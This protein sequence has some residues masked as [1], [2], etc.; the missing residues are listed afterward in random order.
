MESGAGS[1]RESQS[2]RKRA[3]ILDAATSAFL[4]NG[5]VG[6]SIDQ[7][8]A[9][10]GVSKPTVYKHFADKER[11]FNEI[12]LGTID[13]VG[14]PV[15]DVT[16]SLGD[17]D[18][19]NAALDGLA[20]NLVAIVKEP[21]LLELRRLVIGETARFPELSRV[22]F[23][24][25]PGRTI[26]MLADTF[27]QLAERGLLRVTDARLAAQQFIWLVLSIPLNQAMFTLDLDFDAAELDRYAQEAVAVFR[28]AYGRR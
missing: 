11:L 22:Y 28:A 3:A 23:E 12:V 26:D 19:L 6:T 16:A 2:S 25:G 7:I 4:E 21:R 1:A 13:E 24:R 14:R 8:A 20:R 17:A 15:F 9:R 27:G 10:A 18:D 5:Y